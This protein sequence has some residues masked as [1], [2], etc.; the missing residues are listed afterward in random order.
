MLPRL[1]ALK[2]K[3][4]NLE[5]CPKHSQ[6][7]LNS[8]DHHHHSEILRKIAVLVA[9]SLL[10]EDSKIPLR[11]SSQQL[12]GDRQNR[13]M[14]KLSRLQL[15]HLVMGVKKVRYL[16]TKKANSLLLVDLRLGVVDR[17]FSSPHSE[18]VQSGHRVRTQS[19]V[20]QQHLHPSSGVVANRPQ[21]FQQLL[22]N[23]NPYSVK[24]ST[25][26]AHLHL[27]R[28]NTSQMHQA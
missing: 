20:A 21:E 16:R 26:K 22:K 8:V 24:A 4:P 6:M 5:A 1:Q 12:I 27:K 19:S 18:V 23:R 2:R 28:W 11:C 3:S 14:V 15:R 10:L 13:K 7:N 17:K 9:Y 25:L